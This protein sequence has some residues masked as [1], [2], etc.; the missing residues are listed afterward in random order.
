[1]NRML[2]NA[3]QQ[4]ELR[5]ALVS[6][7]ILFDLDIEHAG[8]ELKIHNIYKGRITRIERSLEAVFIDYGA[9]RHGFLPFKEISIEYLKPEH[10]QSDR[11]NFQEGLKVGQELMVQIQKEERGA[12]KGAALTTFISL[13]GRFLV[14]MPN[15]PSAGGISR[16]IENEN[17]AELR[18]IFNQLTVPAGMGL[19]VRTAGADRNLDELQSDLDILLKHWAAIQDAFKSRPAPFLINQENDIVI[20]S[21]RD[22]LRKDISEI[23]VDNPEIFTRTQQYISLVSPDFLNR[24]KLYKDNVP[25]FSRFQIEHQ[26]E[27]AFQREVRLPSGGAIVIDHTEAL[28]SIDINSG[29]ATKGGD[30]EETALNTNLEAADEIARQLRLRD[31]GGL[32]VIDFIDMTSSRNQREVE[33]RLR[34]ALKMDRARVQVGRISRFGLLEMS[35]QRL[36]P[37]LGETSQI[38]CPRCSGQGTIRG[39]ESLALSIIRIVEEDALKEKTVQIQVHIP[40]N[41]ATFLLNEKR[42]TLAEIEHRLKVNILVIPNPHMETP[43]YKVVRLRAD[44]VSTQGEIASYNLAEEPATETITTTTTAVITEQ[45]AVKNIISS[46]AASKAKSGIFG[47]ILSNLFNIQKPTSTSTPTT[48]TKKTAAEETTQPRENEREREEQQQQRQRRNRD[49]KRGGRD[50][51]RR[52]HR[53]R[54]NRGYKQAG[55]RKQKQF[56]EQ[57]Q[58]HRHDHQ[59][60]PHPHHAHEHHA[61]PRDERPHTEQRPEQQRRH[62]NDERQPRHHHEAKATTSEFTQSTEIKTPQFEKPVPQQPVVSERPAPAEPAKVVSPTIEA[63]TTVKAEK[64]NIPD[65]ANINIEPVSEEKVAEFKPRSNRPTTRRF[66]GAAQSRRR[67]Y[68]RTSNNN[69][70]SQDTTT[71]TTSGTEIIDLTHKDEKAEK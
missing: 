42:K 5:V 37:S 59:Q 4:E 40:V 52:D 24:L 1:M 15:N 22:Y 26:I 43:Q 65:I 64:T 23:I 53:D 71:S 50:H 11:P 48:T 41:V 39:I 34:E 21:I 57:R 55:G 8:R 20:R 13:A 60:Q 29:R 46:V 12:K 35:R 16:R 70:N 2:I 6:G 14:L 69:R 27:S 9:E 45:P 3:T 10:R 28:I 61:Q 38:H 58:E 67:G 51:R 68:L 63:Q 62:F 56:G 19:I 44:E 17:R 25:L 7:Q 36:R 33:D 66:G 18:D 54:D 32:I 49:G 30:I 47:R 31:L